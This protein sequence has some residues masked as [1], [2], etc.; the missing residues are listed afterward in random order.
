M[1][2][3]VLL[4]Y[5]LFDNSPTGSLP[6]FWQ[7]FRHL[8]TLWN[9]YTRFLARQRRQSR[10]LHLTIEYWH[11]DFYLYVKAAPIL[12]SCL[13]LFISYPI[14]YKSALPYRQPP[15]RR[16]MLKNS[17]TDIVLHAVAFCAHIRQR[18]MRHILAFSQV[19]FAETCCLAGNCIGLVYPYAEPIS[20]RSDYR[21]IPQ[22]S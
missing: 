1:K 11:F 21:R 9:S 5:L 22:D 3:I 18:Q 10:Q 6:D 13:I 19:T 12:I 17:H 7:D 8:L 20:P 2:E 16:L 14:S 4:L 15:H